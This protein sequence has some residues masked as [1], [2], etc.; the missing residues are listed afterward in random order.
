VIQPQTQGALLMSSMM[1]MAPPHNAALLDRC[2]YALFSRDDACPEDV[3][4]SV[5]SLSIP[6]LVAMAHHPTSSRVL[7]TI[8]ESSTVPYRTKNKFVL[9]FVGHFHELVDDRIGSRV[10]DRMWAGSDPYLKVG[11]DCC[12]DRTPN[13][14]HDFATGEDCQIAFFP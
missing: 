10:G 3:N 7:D 9:R 4:N 12:S 11:V 1:R 14:E 2:V 8:F 6:D 5:N 13:T